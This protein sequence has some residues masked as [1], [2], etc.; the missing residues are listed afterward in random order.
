MLG[1]LEEVLSGAAERLGSEQH[2]QL[3][4][5]RR[6]ALRLMKLVNTLLDFSRIEAGRVQAVYEPTDLSSV[7]AEVASVFRSDVPAAGSALHV[8][9]RRQAEK[10]RPAWTSTVRA[11]VRVSLRPTR[12]SLGCHD[13]R[14]ACARGGL[15]APRTVQEASDMNVRLSFNLMWKKDNPSPVLQK[16]PAQVQGRR[17]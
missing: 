17:N 16:L 14:Q 8:R 4:T 1:P 15:S 3:V 12:P 9:F 10:Y 5:V 2:L 7:T 11:P 13:S 6:N